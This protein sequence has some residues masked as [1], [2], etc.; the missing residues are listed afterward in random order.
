MWPCT[1]PLGIFTPRGGAKKKKTKISKNLS[2]GWFTR[3]SEPKFNTKN[4]PK[5]VIFII[6]DFYFL[7]FFF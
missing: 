1:L 7:L 5:I 3:I 4:K 6:L 2:F